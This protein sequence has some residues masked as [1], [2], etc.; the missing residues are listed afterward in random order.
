VVHG[1]CIA[2]LLV[3]LELLGTDAPPVLECVAQM[4]LV[5]QLELGPHWGSTTSCPEAVCVS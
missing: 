2:D 5:A 4:E 1:S 3:R